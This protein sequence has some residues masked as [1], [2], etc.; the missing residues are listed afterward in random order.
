[1]SSADVVVVGAGLAGLTAAIRP[2]EAGAS[3]DVVARGHAA[4]HWTAGGL[5]VAAPDGAETPGEGIARLQSVAGH[6]Y[7]LLGRDVAAGLDWFRATTSAAAL[8]YS[9]SLSSPIRRV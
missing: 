9:G 5:D 1:M 6:P 7:T 2:A 8:E 3:V 4:T